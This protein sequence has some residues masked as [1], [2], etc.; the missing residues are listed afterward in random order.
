MIALMWRINYQHA[1][2]IK[3]WRGP[4]DGDSVQKKKVKE[5]VSSRIEVPKIQW[6]VGIHT[7]LEVVQKLRVNQ[8]YENKR[9]K[10]LDF[11]V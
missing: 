1:L 9:Q 4:R 11:E 10:T 5:H 8:K 3:N 2:T 6:F 7:N